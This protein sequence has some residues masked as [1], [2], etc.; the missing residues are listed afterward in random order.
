M[1]KETITL[2]QRELDRVWMMEAV[3]AKRLRQREAA[4]QLGRSVRRV[5]IPMPP[6]QKSMTWAFHT[7]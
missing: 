4:L 5:C 7:V 6:K 2:S 1:T 3:I